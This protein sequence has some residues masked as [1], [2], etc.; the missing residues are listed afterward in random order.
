MIVHKTVA[1][2][3]ASALNLILM[4]KLQITAKVFLITKNILFLVSPCNNMITGVFD[5]DSA[6]SW[7]KHRIHIIHDERSTD[8]LSG[9]FK[10]GT[11]LGLKMKTSL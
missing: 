2:Y 7:H 10:E 9:K 3:K 5:K 4:D 11:Y 1:V 6:G 8:F